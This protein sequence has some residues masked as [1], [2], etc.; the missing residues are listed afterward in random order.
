M[1]AR[2]K[3]LWVYAACVL[4]CVFSTTSFSKKF[5]YLSPK[6]RCE[7]ILF[8]KKDLEKFYALAHKKLIQEC[9]KLQPIIDN[10]IRMVFEENIKNK[11]KSVSSGE[12]ERERHYKEWCIKQKN[13]RIPAFIKG[14]EEGIVQKKDAQHENF[15]D[16]SF[17]GKDCIGEPYSQ[18]FVQGKK[19]ISQRE[20]QEEKKKSTSFRKD[21]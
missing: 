21:I 16:V 17:G 18:F 14:P 13:A 6:D 3:F 5:S 11:E 7:L 19:V 10:K 2:K 4:C 15:S 12:D 1:I 8:I 9:E 20:D